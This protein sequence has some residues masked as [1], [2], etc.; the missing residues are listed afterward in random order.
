MKYYAPVDIGVGLHWHHFG[1]A[2]LPPIIETS[3]IS[4]EPIKTKIVVY[5][6]FEDTNDVIRQLSAFKNFEFHVY[7]AENVQSSHDY[8]ICKPLSR[9][10]FQADLVDCTG[11]ISNAG[12]ELASEALQMG[13]KILVETIARAN[14]ASLECGCI[15]PTGLRACDERY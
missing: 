4:K 6:P 7:T 5:L 11:I 1:Q 13:K 3:P 2:I 14:G 15:A 9:D 8:I 12:F 10:G